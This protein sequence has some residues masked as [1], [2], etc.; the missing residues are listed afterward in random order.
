MSG[1]LIFTSGSLLKAAIQGL[2]LDLMTLVVKSLMFLG[3]RAVYY[4]QALNRHRLN[5]QTQ[6][7]CERALFSFPGASS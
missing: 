4:P 2:S 1:T 6:Y 7:F 3:A 5:L